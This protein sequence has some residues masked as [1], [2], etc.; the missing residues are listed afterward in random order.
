MTPAP[1][2]K[3]G[4]L[5]RHW[6]LCSLGV[7]AI[8]VIAAAVVV[9]RTINGPVPAK[10][11]TSNVVFSQPEAPHLV[12]NP[13]ERVYRIDPTKSSVQYRVKEKLFGVGVHTAHGL[14]NGI[15]G[16]LAL[17]ANAPAQS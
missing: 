3:R 10:Y 4:F 12:A 9:W 7:I 13:G 11:A 15:A 2:R 16:D 1:A 5:R 8:G 17:N 14:T 6:I